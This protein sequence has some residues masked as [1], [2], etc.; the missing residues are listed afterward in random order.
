MSLYG[1]VRSILLPYALR[2]RRTNEHDIPF[3]CGVRS[4]LVT[5]HK[6]DVKKANTTPVTAVAVSLNYKYNLCIGIEHERPTRQTIMPTN[7]SGS[8]GLT[9]P[10]HLLPSAARPLLPPPRGKRAR[11]HEGKRAEQLQLIAS[12]GSKRFRPAARAMRR[13]DCRSTR[14][15]HSGTRQSS[16]WPCAA[17]SAS[18][19]DSAVPGRGYRPWQK[20][21]R[22]ASQTARCSIVPHWMMPRSAPGSSTRSWSAMYSSW[23]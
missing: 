2:V 3:S 9:T 13:A 15:R 11:G 17:F 8:L 6:C 16:V 14:A 23:T 18:L 22:R 7:T 12:S 20:L 4:S 5:P 10:P 21:A 19:V 1:Y